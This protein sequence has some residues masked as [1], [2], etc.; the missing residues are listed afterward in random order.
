M[1]GQRGEEAGASQSWGSRPL[2][3]VCAC[4]RHFF[5]VRLR[6]QT[7][8]LK[9]AAVSSAGGGERWR[10]GQ[11]P[12]KEVTSIFMALDMHMLSTFNMWR[13]GKVF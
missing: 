5:D 2:V 4:A 10:E 13:Q 3:H 8:S 12:K 6:L 11:A 9:G 7:C 1:K